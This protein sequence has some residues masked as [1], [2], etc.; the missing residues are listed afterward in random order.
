MERL[1]KG[2]HLYI[3]YK[4]HEDL[5]LWIMSEHEKQYLEW[6]QK[7]V[8][9]SLVALQCDDWNRELSP[10]QAPPVFKN[11]YFLGYGHQTYEMIINDLIPYLR[12]HYVF[13]H[14]YIVGYS[15]AGLFSLYVMSLSD[16]FA[17]AGSCSGSLWYPEFDTFLFQHHITHHRI[18][19]SLGSKEHK[20]RHPVISQVK[21]KT[22]MTYHFYLQDNECVLKYEPGHHFQQIEQR[23]FHAMIWLSKGEKLK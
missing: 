12:D 3:E 2:H 8:A 20:T 15:L 7:K 5:I 14:L 4:H 13:R 19:L 10:W 1:M 17:G 16:Q 11:N 21:V 18:Y 22:E 23:L 6:M 9:C